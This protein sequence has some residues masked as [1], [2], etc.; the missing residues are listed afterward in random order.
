MASNSLQAPTAKT[1]SNPGVATNSSALYCWPLILLFYSILIP[2]EMFIDFGGL[3]LYGFRLTEFLLLPV[4]FSRFWNGNI[5]INVA[6]ILVVL[7]GGWILISL[8]FVHDLVFALERGGSFSADMLLAYLIGRVSIR[9][10]ADI[11][12]FLT[13]VFP[14]VLAAGLLL[15]AE[16]ISGSH[17][18]R[19]NVSKIFGSDV[20]GLFKLRQ[21]FRVGLLR[22]YGPFVHPIAAGIV[23]TSFVPL[24][25][26][27]FSRSHLR[28]T[29]SGAAFLG[30]FCLSSSALLSLITAFSLIG[31]DRVRGWIK[32]ISWP[33]ILSIM[34]AAAALVQLTSQNG[35]ISA[36]YR[37]FT[38]NPATGY[39]RT[40]IWEYAGAEALRN[41][42]F[43]I[44][45]N[46]WER[47]VWM[48]HYSVD[49]HFLYLALQNGLV[50]SLS[51][52]GAFIW[53][54]SKLAFIIGKQPSVNRRRIL[55]GM[56]FCL[57][58]LLMTLFTVS[59][60][61]STG[62]FVMMLL[63]AAATL[64]HISNV[65]LAQMVWHRQKMAALNAMSSQPS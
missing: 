59:V 46:D 45:L 62:A 58:I 44:G 65:E 51:L 50:A 60:T 57:S 1:H 36:L 15:M 48:L 26:M 8:A 42:I 6:D 30:V 5:K 63:G 19:G 31:L 25:F 4:I 16:S 3:R 23:I 61:T 13:F 27:C 29:G 43:G 22:A 52:L 49:A 40:L 32:E 12:S 33:V 47:P 35:I 38:F 20:E 14:G 34:A 53:T 7:A 39:Y 11:R 56:V 55:M 41:P 9:R 10:M 21:E 24:Y 54:I 64:I 28:L 2:P 37:Y 17:L 18:L